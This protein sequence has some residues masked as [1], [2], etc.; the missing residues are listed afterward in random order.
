MK[1]KTVN[2]ALHA[3]LRIQNAG[4]KAAFGAISIENGDGLE[5]AVRS[6]LWR[7]LR[8]ELRCREP[9]VVLPKLPELTMNEEPGREEG[10]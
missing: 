5:A 8:G 6:S 9:K 10:R 3:V 2:D 1:T 4:P 7:C